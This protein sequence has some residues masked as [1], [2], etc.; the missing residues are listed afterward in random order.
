MSR[1]IPTGVFVS[2]LPTYSSTSWTA[3]AETRLL[4]K[5]QV[6][7]LR[8]LLGKALFEAE[9][10]TEGDCA[11]LFSLV[12]RLGSLDERTFVQK[13]GFLLFLL[14]G[15][16]FDLGPNSVTEGIKVLK[17][18]FPKLLPHSREYFSR[19]SAIPPALLRIIW[20]QPKRFSPKKFVGVGFDTT[21]TSR[22]VATDAS[23]SWAEVAMDE[24]FQGHC[25]PRWKYISP[26]NARSTAVHWYPPNSR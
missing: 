11:E 1:T 10:F 26:V 18:T 20:R 22:N 3:L 9:L 2:D 8:F 7:W 6:E 19:K 13:W 15:I 24:W 16:R 17:Q 25:K 21:N 12:F 5:K 4:P 23:P 14:L